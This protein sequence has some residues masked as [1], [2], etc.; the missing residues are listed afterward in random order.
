MRISSKLMLLISL[1]ILMIAFQFGV[2]RYLNYKMKIY[3][4]GIRQLSK[5]SDY[6]LSGIIEEKS[7]IDNEGKES[8]DNAIMFVNHAED[9]ILAMEA[10]TIVSKEDLSSLRNLLGNYRD[11]FG[12]L[13]RVT[14]NLSATEGEFQAILTEFNEKSKTILRKINEEVGTRLVNSE[15]VPEHLRSLVDM[16][17][18]VALLLHQW[19]LILNHGLLVKDDLTEYTDSSEKVLAELQREKKNAEAIASFIKD[20]EYSDFIRNT[21]VRT[22]NGMPAYALKIRQLWTER[23]KTQSE[24]NRIRDQLRMVKEEVYS[25]S[26]EH[27]TRFGRQLLA[28]NVVVFLFS[29]LTML[30]AG[31]MLYRSITGPIRSITNSA[32][33]IAG[34]DLHHAEESFKGFLGHTDDFNAGR[35]ERKDEVRQLSSAFYRMTRSLHSLI[36]QVRNSGIQVVSSATQISASA[37]ELEA[38]ATQQAASITQVSATAREISTG[39]RELVR[40]MSEVAS[41]AAEAASLAEDGHKGLQNMEAA[42]NR[43]VEGTAS[44]ASKLEA[45]SDK[46]NNIGSIVTT[47]TKVADQT[48]LLSLN[49]AIEAEKAG[50]YG[51]GFSVV[52]REIR[53]LADQT[54]VATL[55]IEQMVKEMQSAVSS[56]VMEVDKFVQQVRQGG[57]GIRKISGQIAGII[58]HVQTVIPRFESVNEGMGIQ[59]TGAEE[60]SRAMVQLAEGAEQTRQVVLEFNRAV[61]QLTEAVQGLQK[62]VSKFKLDV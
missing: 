44:I 41:V 5:A 51:L 12:R 34:G 18:E 49:A 6:V 45:I 56:G 46:T 40:T 31:V 9:A 50:E 7:Y 39:T 3:T 10:G 2:S 15:E 33:T 52:A 11:A 14:R 4:E 28:T 30:G 36:S 32:E 20:V 23:I 16:T 47:I 8:F 42:M 54:A 57:D 29:V 13:G 35:E 19:S 58:G 38:T 43:L 25:E 55:D 60:I 26:N 53:R 27:I 1:G 48:N 17:R 59:S 21:L 22:I 24:L 62:E 61:E 37:R